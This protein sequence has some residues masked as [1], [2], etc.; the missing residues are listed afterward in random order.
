MTQHTTMKQHTTD[1]PCVFCEIV[2]GRAPHSV[3]H[4][5]DR[6]LAFMDIQPVLTGHVLVVPKAHATY[7]EDLDPELGAD[8]F[9]VAH[10]VARSLPLSGV[11]CEGVNLFLANGVAAFQEVFHVHL[12]V[13]PRVS[14]DGF[15]FQ[16]ASYRRDRVELDAT[17]ELVRH[18]L[19]VLDGSL[20]RPGGAG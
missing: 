19:S 16:N 8:V 7:L 20:S 15:H 1:L 10:R 18:G 6:V 13:F 5:D 17:A 9:R 11:P 4:E 3:V 14:G 2:A 12:H